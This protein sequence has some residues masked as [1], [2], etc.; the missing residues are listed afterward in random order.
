MQ[1]IQT[2]ITVAQAGGAVACE[3]LLDEGLAFEERD[4]TTL[5]RP[6]PGTL[7]LT[8][9]LDPAEADEWQQRLR[10]RFMQAGIDARMQSVPCDSDTWRDAWKAYFKP[11]HVGPFVIVPSW[12][13]YHP[14]PG[15]TVIDLDPGRAFGTG[16][17]AST[18]L[19]LRALGKITQVEHFL[20]VGCGS[21]V[22]AIACAKRFPRSHGLAVDCDSEAVDTTNENAI[23][24]GVDARIAA[25]TTP[26]GELT[27]SFDLVLANI[28]APT[29]TELAGELAARVAP[30]GRLVGSGILTVE[31][32]RLTPVFAA[33]GLT[34][35]ERDFEDEW[36]ALTFIRPV[37]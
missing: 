21:G 13:E 7:G 9:Y 14:V 36:T 26:V 16:G 24:N 3:V 1:L 31:A 25:A 6:E 19:C 35:A 8:I 11:L 28:S 23:H 12:E 17:H 18:R 32:D 34:L 5:D 15:E 33:Y 2:T 22:L 20:D 4:A 10:Q 30:G 27:G 29:L 37:M